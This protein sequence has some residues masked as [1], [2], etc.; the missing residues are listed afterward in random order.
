MQK[1]TALNYKRHHGK[2]GWWNKPSHA[3]LVAG[4]KP[5]LRKGPF[6][7]VWVNPKQPVLVEEEDDD[8]DP[9]EGMKD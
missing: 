5:I 7:L 1:Q 2:R 6:T 4:L 8:G 9:Q 3:E